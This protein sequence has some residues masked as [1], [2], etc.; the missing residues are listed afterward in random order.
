MTRVDLERLSPK[1]QAYIRKRQH[2]SETHRKPQ[3]RRPKPTGLGEVFDSQLELDFA[4]VLQ[5]WML[6]QTISEWRYH[7]LRFRLAPSVTYE[8]D[9]LIVPHLNEFPLTIYETKGSWLS[10]NARDSRTRLQI[11]AHRYPWFHWY[12]ATREKG[13]W[14]YEVIHAKDAEGE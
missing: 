3:D 5:G 8:P 9:F 6:D 1:H 7:P 10:K 11:A 4:Q 2:S 14:Q 13:V 12:A